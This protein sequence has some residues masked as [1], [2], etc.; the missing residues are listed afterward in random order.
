MDRIRIVGG[1]ALNGLDSDLG[2]EE[3]HAAADDREPCSPIRR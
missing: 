2:R 3:R 1:K